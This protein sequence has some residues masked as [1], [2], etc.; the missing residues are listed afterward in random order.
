MKHSDKLLIKETI[1]KLQLLPGFEPYPHG[2]ESTTLTTAPIPNSK[3][4]TTSQEKPTRYLVFYMLI[5]IRTIFNAI[6]Y[7]VKAVWIK[8]EETMRK[9]QLLPGI[10]PHPQR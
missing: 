2:W 6:Q 3:S 4:Q 10:E 1:K 8:L 9:L 7:Y 5:R